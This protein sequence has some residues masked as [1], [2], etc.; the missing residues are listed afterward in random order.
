[1]QCTAWPYRW[2]SCAPP[3]TR[4]PGAI[5]AFSLAENN[6]ATAL[7]K[8]LTFAGGALKP[9]R[10]I[11]DELVTRYEEAGWWTR[12]TLVQVLAHRLQAAPDSTFRVYS[13][14]RPW[15]GTFADVE[16]VAGRR[17]A[18]LR[19]RGVG[20]GDGVAVQL[21]DWMEAAATV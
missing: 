10:N 1:M 13:D 12:E 17:A 3:A 18:G 19:A 14:V 7:L 5:L 21:P 11:P 6:I 16:A 9:M 8:T 4:I 2:L 20:A 15:S